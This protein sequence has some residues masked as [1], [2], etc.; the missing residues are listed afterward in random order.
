MESHNLLLTI[1]GMSCA[2]CVSTVEKSLA[3]LPGVEQVSVSFANQSALVVGDVSMD[4]AVDAVKKAGY[5]ARPLDNQ[6][7]EVQEAAARVELIRSAIRSAVAL[8]AGAL[9]MVDMMVGL[10][11]PLPSTLTWGLIGLLT[12]AIMM[13]SG[14]HFYRGAFQ[15]LRTGT[16]TMDTLITLGTGT[17]W[18]YSMLVVLFPE[19]IPADSRHQFFEA[20][21]FIIGFVN[22]GKALETHARTRASLA[23]RKLFDLT[24]KYALVVD[25]EEET[26]LPVAALQ[27]GQQ[28]RLRPGDYVPVDA[29]IVSGEGSFDEAVLTGESVPV[30]REPGDLVRAGTINLDGSLVVSATAVGAETTLARMVHLVQE[31]QNTKPQIG[32]LVD[33]ISAVFVPVVVLIAVMTAG[34]WWWFGPEPQLSFML[35]TTMSVLII[36]CP[37]ALGLA[38]PMSITMGMGRG[39]ARG[40][41]IRNSEVLQTASRMTT[42][43]VDKTGTLTLGQPVVVKTVDLNETEQELF[44]ALASLSNHPLSQAIAADYPATRGSEV[45]NFESVSGGGLSGYLDGH[46]LL[47]GSREFVEQRL[48]TLLPDLPEQDAEGSVV[49]AALDGSPRGYFLL[50]DEVRHDVPAMIETLKDRGV[51]IIM[52]T[53]DRQGAAQSVA[54]MTGITTFHTGLLPEDKLRI[55]QDLQSQG[56]VVGMAGDG[57][58]DAAALAAADIGFAMGGGTDIAMETAD[59]TL[60]KDSLK[61]IEDAIQLSRQTT[62]NIYQNL[63]LASIYNL[64][65]IPVAAGVLYPVTGILINPALAGLAMAVS[66]IT[67]VFNASRL[68]LS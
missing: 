18:A 5:Q 46:S 19:V 57:I 33:R 62:G 42:L 56:Q 65:L 52:L 45:I 13:I 31:A 20:A 64:L 44:A 35:V 24:P 14:G 23:I 29:Q 66:S 37:C 47:L 58:N 59:V 4:S 38:V 21:L 1:N 41:L 7:L 10:L 12:L 3:Q 26:S 34:I 36:A 51:D 6:P 68:R 67:V 63:F 22:F 49:F 39:A 8:F 32:R 55:I 9:L 60:L 40:L 61:G 54:D 11:P 30:V 2:G 17:A 16:A 27:P 43:V 53:G 48:R 15:A 50:Q 28:L 25:G